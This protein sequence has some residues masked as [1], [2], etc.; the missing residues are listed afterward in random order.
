MANRDLATIFAQNPVVTPGQNDPFYIGDGGS[1]DGGI[2]RRHLAGVTEDNIIAG[3]SYTFVDLDIAR[4]VVSNSASETTFTVPHSTVVSFP[5]TTY[6]PLEQRNTGQLVVVGA[7]TPAQVQIRV[8][9]SFLA[10]LRGQYATAFLKKIN[11][12][13]WLLGGL[14]ADA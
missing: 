12:D 4:W 5:I 7:A 8:H 3:T 9:A 13:E 2:A 1:Q 6:I 11:V 10:R 14:L